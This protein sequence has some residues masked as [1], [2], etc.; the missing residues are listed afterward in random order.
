[1]I[2][3]DARDFAVGEAMNQNSPFFITTDRIAF[4]RW[5]SDDLPLALALWGDPAVARLTHASGPPSAAAIA[6]RLER[7]IATEHAHGLSYWPIFLRDGDEHIGCC[8]LRPYRLAEAVHELGFHLRPDHWGKGLAFE[9]A[10][11]VVEHA[12][13]NLGAQALFAGHHPENAASRRLLSKLGFRYTHDELYPPTGLQHP[14]Y[15]LDR[16]TH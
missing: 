14:S 3:A 15:L 4:R 2:G 12:F 1:V 7:E 11:A 6:A 8:G 10:R 16:T 9:A 13:S 5:R